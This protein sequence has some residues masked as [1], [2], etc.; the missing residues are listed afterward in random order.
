MSNPKSQHYVPQYYLAGF[1]DNSSNNLISVYE[2]GTARHF[3]T[4]P[5]N[6][7]VETYF[8]AYTKPDGTLENSFESYLANDIEASANPVIDKI[9]NYQPI[10]LAEKVAFATYIAVQLKRVPAVRAQVQQNAPNIVQ[11]IRQELVAEFERAIAENPEK[12]AILEANREKALAYLEEVQ[13][14]VPKQ[15]QIQLITPSLAGYINA[16]TWQFLVFN[17]ATPF[18]T[19]DNPVFY[20]KSIGIGQAMSEITFPI[21][22]SIALWVTWRQDL[23][24]GYVQTTEQ[25]VR[26]INQRTASTAHRYIFSPVET[27]WISNLAKQTNFD[28]RILK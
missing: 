11:S 1:T 16:M 19:S 27:H 2:K 4:S 12:A 24:E 15:I 7:A 13:Q 25:C 3:R 5:Q 22:K 10:S 8:Y 9:R 6:I 17:R 26:Q 21:S 23:V 18:L 20:F 28:L 14:N